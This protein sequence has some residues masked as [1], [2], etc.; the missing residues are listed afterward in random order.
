MNKASIQQI[1][2]Y[3]FASGVSELHIDKTVPKIS[4]GKLDEL[5]STLSFE[6]ALN[7]CT[8][9]CSLGVQKKYPG[10]HINWWN[11]K[12]AV[13]MLRKAGFKTIYRSGWGQSGFPVLRNTSLFDNT[14]P[15]ISL[16]IEARK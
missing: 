9:N 7:F 8:S 10:N 5:F 13:K 15:K 2:L 3:H 1:F 16:Y 12:K 11:E 6:D 4:D 14:H